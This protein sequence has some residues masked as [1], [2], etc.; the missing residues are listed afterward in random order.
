MWNTF[1]EDG[2]IGALYKCFMK[3]NKIFNLLFDWTLVDQ[4]Q[5]NAIKQ[6][7]NNIHSFTLEQLF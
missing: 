3:A 5:S 6:G 7:V 4:F 1:V 2:G